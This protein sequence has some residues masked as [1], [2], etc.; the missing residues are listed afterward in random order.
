MV[1]D[2][3]SRIWMEYPVPSVLDTIKTDLR[4][5]SLKEETRTREN[6]RQGNVPASW[7]IQTT[8]VWTK[9]QIYRHTVNA[10]ILSLFRSSL[11]S[12]NK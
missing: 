7:D 9:F 11:L 12:L 3:G 4:Y 8:I 6:L 10:G 2:T 1:L 5:L